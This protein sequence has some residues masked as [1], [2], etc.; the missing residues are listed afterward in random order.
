MRF[1]HRDVVVSL[2][3]YD[4]KQSNDCEWVVLPVASFDCYY[5]NT[6]FIKKR[7]AKIPKDILTREVNSGVCRIKVNI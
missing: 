5:G 1:L 7:L 2:A 4:A 6:N 3:C